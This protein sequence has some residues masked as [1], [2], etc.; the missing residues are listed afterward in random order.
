MVGNLVYSKPLNLSRKQHDHGRC[1]EKQRAVYISEVYFKRRI[2]RLII[3]IS[4]QSPKMSELE[5]ILHISSAH[6]P[7]YRKGN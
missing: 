2:S 1:R 3:N 5:I 6:P 7:L 4:D